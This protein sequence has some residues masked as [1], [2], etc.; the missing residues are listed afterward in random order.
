MRQRHGEPA[1]GVSGG[2]SSGVGLEPSVEIVRDAR[3]ERAVTTPQQVDEPAGARGAAVRGRGGHKRLRSEG[4][5]CVWPRNITHNAAITSGG[6]AAICFRTQSGGSLSEIK[7]FDKMAEGSISPVESDLESPYCSS[8]FFF[9][10]NCCPSTPR[11]GTWVRNSTAAPPAKASGAV[12]SL[13]SC[14]S[15]RLAAC[16]DCAG[17]CAAFSPAARAK[18]S[19]VT[20]KE[21]FRATSGLL[22][23]Q[24]QTTW[25]GNSSASSVSRDA[26]RLWNSFGQAGILAASRIRRNC[27]AIES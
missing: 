9:V 4:E 8:V 20:V 13:S 22:P 15:V 1:A 21:C 12:V 11:G 26:R 24:P 14:K 7:G 18:W 6:S 5:P 10:P 16:T 3:V 25:I 27:D 17:F 2:G 23:I 19:S